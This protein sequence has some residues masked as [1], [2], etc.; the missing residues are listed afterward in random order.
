MKL[1]KENET[2]ACEVHGWTLQEDH[3]CGLPPPE[4]VV[5]SE[6]G[7]AEAR[8]AASPGCGFSRHRGHNRV[9]LVDADWMVGNMPRHFLV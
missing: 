5:G 8:T 9:V 1:L 6:L 2:F 7:V 3:A 4:R